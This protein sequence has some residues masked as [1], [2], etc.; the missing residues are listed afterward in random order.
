MTRAAWAGTALLGLGLLLLATTQPWVRTVTELAPGAPRSRGAVDGAEVVPWL[1]AVALVAAVALLL[2][3]ARVRAAGPV[4]LLACAGVLAGAA[5]GALAGVDPRRGEGVVS[6]VAT[7]WLWVGCAAA[8][9]GA[10]AGGLAVLGPRAP[11]RR[12]G[13]Q[14]GAPGPGADPDG[15]EARRRRDARDWRDL[16]EGRDPTQGPDAG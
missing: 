5:A 1:V 9:L 11:A 12:V 7:G 8:V 6:A 13:E 10:V 2:R 3:L 15:S 16:T 4:V 14:T